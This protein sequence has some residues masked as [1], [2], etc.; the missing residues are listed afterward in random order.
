MTGFG[1]LCGTW[2]AWLPLGMLA[3]CAV[4]PP[5]EDGKA[6]HGKPILECPPASC[7]PL[8]CPPPPRHPAE[9]LLVYGDRVGQMT[10]QELKSEYDGLVT[11]LDPDGIRTLRMALVLMSP[12]TPFRDEGAALRLLQEWE[13]ARPGPTPTAAVDG[14]DPE[15]ALRAFVRVQRAVL[16]DRARSHANLDNCQAKQREDGKRADACQEKLEAIRNLEKTLLER[17]KR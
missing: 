17:D 11:A 6:A 14:V 4:L 10:A 5:A 8:A 2:L 16:Q 12:N 9:S 15:A 7:P 13:K 3:G 1:R